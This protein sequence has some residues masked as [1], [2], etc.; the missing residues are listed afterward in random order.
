[1]GDNRKIISSLIITATILLTPSLFWLSDKLI[2]A[3]IM[4]LTPIGTSMDEIESLVQERRAWER[5]YPISEAALGEGERIIWVR[6]RR[7]VFKPIRIR[8]RS[9]SDSKL[10]D[11]YIETKLIGL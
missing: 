5:N 1:M 8:W 10:I 6:I 11:V 3:R 7:S 2:R 4:Q 9:D